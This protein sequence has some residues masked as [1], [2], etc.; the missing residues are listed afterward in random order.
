MSAPLLANQYLGPFDLLWEAVQRGAV[1]LTS[2]S[3]ADITAAYLQ[4]LSQLTEPQPDE[5]SAFVELGARL[6]YLKSQA[7]LPQPETNPA[8]GLEIEA[9]S[10]QLQDYQ[11]VKQQAAALRPLA[12]ASTWRR[13]AQRRAKRA[14]TAYGPTATRPH[15]LH[16]D[17][18]QS[19]YQAMVARQPKLAPVTIQPITRFSLAEATILI[20]QQLA[21]GRSTL[22][23]L[24]NQAP[25]EHQHRLIVVFLA[26]LELIKQGNVQLIAPHASHN[27][28]NAQLELRHV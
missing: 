4:K 25:R 8:D 5:L 2:V 7:L 13:P 26:V 14:A 10:H 11:L 28:L 1:E 19:A 20:Q 24:S 9:L 21:S 18:L 3:L 17:S 23:E 6:V 16:L 15:N 12:H 27:S 22:G